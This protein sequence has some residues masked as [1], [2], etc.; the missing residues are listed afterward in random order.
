MRQDADRVVIDFNKGMH[1]VFTQSWT[2]GGWL[3][4]DRRDEVLE[5]PESRVFE[6]RPEEG[7]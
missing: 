3:D 2:D 5:V 6:M 1:R 7:R 4:F